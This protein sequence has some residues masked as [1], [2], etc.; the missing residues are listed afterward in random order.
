VDG[1]WYGHVGWLFARDL[2]HPDYRVVRDL[3]RYPEVVW[4]D[5]LWMVPGLLL[6]A[7]CYWACGWGGVVYG[8]CLSVVLVFQVTFAVNS[9]GHL[10]GPQRFDTGDGSRNNFVLGILAMGDGWHNNHH[11]A[12]T[13]A[14]HGFAW[15]E[16]DLSF[17]T[18]RLLERLGLVWGVKL[19]PAH[20][21]NG[22]PRPPAPGQGVPAPV[23][24]H[25]Q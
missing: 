15:Y 20:V 25:P 9:V 4:L 1:F 11:R 2:M 3:A 24:G 19:P 18:I 21:L 8:Y 10:F 13:S 16:F 23:G 6:A 14:R 17:L 7:A 12:P 5:R 22:E